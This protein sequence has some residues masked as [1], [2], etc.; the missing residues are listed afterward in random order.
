MKTARQIAQELYT[1]LARDAHNPVGSIESAL[2]EYSDSRLEDA[3]KQSG[4]FIRTYKTSSHAP[5]ASPAKEENV[6]LTPEREKEIRRCT[7]GDVSDYD[8]L[9]D[10]LAEI[11]ALREDKDSWTV[12]ATILMK[13][14]DK[15]IYAFEK[16]INGRF[17]IGNDENGNVFGPPD[18]V[19]CRK[20]AGDAIDACRGEGK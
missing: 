5:A 14:R 12:T 8:M 1:K 6:R 15:L 2:I 17:H 11:N 20:I 9:G 18:S 7:A 16:I 13:E 4:A 19:M 10:L 3:A